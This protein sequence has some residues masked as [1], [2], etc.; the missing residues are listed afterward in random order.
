MH[1]AIYDAVNAI[2]RTHKP[3]LVRL[4]GVSRDHKRQQRQQRHTKSSLPCIRRSR[5][6]LMPNFCSHWHRFPRD[7]ARLRAS[8]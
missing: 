7:W 2:D 5:A 4:S 8:A 3:Y 1:A 6:H